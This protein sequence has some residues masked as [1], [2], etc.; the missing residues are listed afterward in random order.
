MRLLLDNTPFS[1]ALEQETNRILRDLL[2]VDPERY[3]G[4][5]IAGKIS[6]NPDTP[7]HLNEFRIRTLEK[8][9]QPKEHTLNDLDTRERYILENALRLKL[10]LNDLKRGK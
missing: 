10:D 5:D 3:Y 9:R 4:A 2:Q 7:G 8:R 1:E 6:V